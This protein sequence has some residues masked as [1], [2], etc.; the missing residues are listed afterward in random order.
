VPEIP[1]RTLADLFSGNPNQLLPTN[2]KKV[3]AQ[4]NASLLIVQ[5]RM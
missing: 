2:R 3:S 5:L 1:L 4:Q